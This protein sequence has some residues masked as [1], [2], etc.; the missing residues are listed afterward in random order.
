MRQQIHQIATVLSLLGGL[1]GCASVQS[2]SAP[3]G[4]T[5]I[6]VPYFMPR[7]PFVV[8]ISTPAGV[9]T[10][11]ATVASGTAEPDLTR[12]F[13]LTQGTNLLAK[14]ELNIAVGANG[15]LMTSNTTV[16]SEVSTAVQNAANSVAVFAGLPPGVPLIGQAAANPLLL[17]E[18]IGPLKLMQPPVL[19]PVPSP[20]IPHPQIEIGCPLA[21]TS[22]Q[23]VI[24]P[25]DR[26]TQNETDPVFCNYTIRWHLSGLGENRNPVSDTK[27][28]TS[29]D[30][31]SGVFFRHELPYQVDIT[32][33]AAFTGQISG[34]TLTIDADSV[35]SGV[36][37]I[38]QA[39]TDPSGRVQ[40]GTIIIS[41]AG[42]SWKVNV[43]QNVAKESMFSAGAAANASFTGSI[44]GNTLTISNLASGIVAIGQEIKDSPEAAHP[45][46]RSGT[47][48]TAHP[49]PTTWTVNIAQN[50]MSASMIGLGANGV[51][52]TNRFVL[53]SPD[54]SE[55]D[56]FPVNHSFFADNTANIAITNGVIT[57]IDQTKDGEV[58]AFV[59]LPATFISSYTTALGNLLT[60]FTSNSSDQQK[61][62]Q[63]VQSATVAQVQGAAI[64][65]A[66]AQ[67]CQKTAA[68]YNFATMN[69]AQATAAAAAIQAACSSSS[70]S[71][72]GSNSNSNI[73][74]G[75]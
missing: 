51:A 75:H 37:A 74:S 59:G 70:T 34:D 35:A 23:Y 61:L 69:A 29:T 22:Y 33:G 20:P 32:A 62:I 26:P 36:I 57:S 17:N 38:G 73:S 31:M 44:S 3:S 4:A 64:A 6:G 40:L 68:S 1:A 11:T 10:P 41:G 60:G 49:S 63:Q 25:E 43:R 45:M 71:S 28:A 55:I 56:F 5:P 48:I 15:L 66:Q 72:S 9:G 19:R 8:T 27:N 12:R 14:N 16:N 58:A 7:R 39:I 53:T 2:A 30:N 13:V 47:Y 65:Q 52:S 54:E 42:T 21:G 50:V 67:V 24:Y 46:I 18:P